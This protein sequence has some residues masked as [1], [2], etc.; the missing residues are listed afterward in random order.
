MMFK[1]ALL[2]WVAPLVVF[3]LPWAGPALE[4]KWRR[5]AL[6]ALVW[7]ATVA[8]TL[9]K[10]AGPGLLVWAALGLASVMFCHVGA[11]KG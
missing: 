2:F 5:A 7:L 10:W 6:W 8:V 3:V 9:L 4:G 1:R 11:D